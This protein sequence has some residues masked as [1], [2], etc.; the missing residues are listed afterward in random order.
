MTISKRDYESPTVDV[1]E[2]RVE[3]AILALSGDTTTE[4]GGFIDDIPWTTI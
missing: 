2:L 1:L 3:N 4:P